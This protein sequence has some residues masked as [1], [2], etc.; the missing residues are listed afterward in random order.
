MKSAQLPANEKDRLAALQSL[1][2]TTLPMSRNNSRGAVNAFSIAVRRHLRIVNPSQGRSPL[3]QLFLI[4]SNIGEKVG[5][6]IENPCVGGSI[7]PQATKKYAIKSNGYT[8]RLVAIF[9]PEIFCRQVVS[10]L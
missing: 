7:L 4:R 8:L 5:R 1:A 6:R 9:L 2:G 3:M 10:Y